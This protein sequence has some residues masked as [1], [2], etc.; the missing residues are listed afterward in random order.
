MGNNYTGRRRR[1]EEEGYNILCK[2]LYGC[3]QIDLFLSSHLMCFCNK[4]IKGIKQLKLKEIHVIT[5]T[6]PG[7]IFRNRLVPKKKQNSV[8]NCVACHL[9]LLKK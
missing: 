6:F 8:I 5:E 9:L 2:Y 1:E 7:H 4:K 3:F